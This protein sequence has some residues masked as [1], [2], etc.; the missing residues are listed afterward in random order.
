MHDWECEGRVHVHGFSRQLPLPPAYVC[1]LCFCPSTTE[2]PLTT[3]DSSDRVQTTSSLQESTQI[4]RPITPSLEVGFPGV[5]QCHSSW[6]S[7]CCE[8]FCHYL[9]SALPYF[10][11]SVHLGTSR[12]RRAE[13]TGQLPVCG[14]CPQWDP[15]PQ[16]SQVLPT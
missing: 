15:S 4:C 1:A 5:P 10:P 12:S 8:L 2:D 14:S 9:F 13:S 3:K 6:S 7:D 16:S 11:L